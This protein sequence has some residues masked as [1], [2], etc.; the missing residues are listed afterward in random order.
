[1]KQSTA[2][3]MG[4]ARLKACKMM[5]YF[6]TLVYSLIPAEVP[7]CGTMFVTAGL[8]LG[9]DPKFVEGLEEDVL[10]GVLLHEVN[11]IVRLYFNRLPTADPHLRNQASDI[12]INHDLSKCGVKLP[13][14]AIFPSTYGFKEGLTMEEYY[15]LLLEKQAKEPQPL[16][17]AL[18]LSGPCSGHCGGVAGNPIDQALENELDKRGRAG[19]DVK[20]KVKQAAEDI[21]RYAQKGRGNLPKDL[22][23][24]A[25]AAMGPAKIPWSRILHHKMSRTMNKIKSGMSD[26]S[27][28]RMHRHQFARGDDIIRP[29]M[30][31]YELEVMFVLDTSGSMGDEEVGAALRETVGVMKEL[32]IT[33]VLFMQADAAVNVEPNY[34]RV[35]D[36]QN[37]EIRGR[38]GTDFRPAIAYAERMNRR[39]PDLLIYLTDGD[40][41]A[42][43]I[44]PRGFEVIW[45]V[46]P[47]YQRKPPAPWGQTVFVD[48]KEAEEEEV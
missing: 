10:A 35:R 13:E 1:M 46:V 3:K 31:A 21:R 37:L 4:R 11:H 17:I 29:G 41:T 42:P 18:K 33:E 48:T 15:E 38:G 44:K 40:G 2:S 39:K 23:D 5:P 6:S 26:Y 20:S 30:V 34:L 27:M 32:D 12:P 45:C 7:E 28:A 16:H 14:G 22:V 19:P 47:S 24:A 8:V 36:L 9:F 43:N 25:E